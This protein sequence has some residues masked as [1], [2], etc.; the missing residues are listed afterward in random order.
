MLDARPCDDPMS[1]GVPWRL[2]ILLGSLQEDGVISQ[3]KVLGD[4]KEI[5][6]VFFGSHSNSSKRTIVVRNL[7]HNLQRNIRPREGHLGVTCMLTSF[8][9]VTSAACAGT[10]TGE[11]VRKQS[12]SA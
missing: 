5:L 6:K 12:R 11:N 7:H 2:D 8:L 10:W 3:C 9:D 4:G 1:F